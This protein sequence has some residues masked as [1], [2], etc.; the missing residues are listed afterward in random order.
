VVQVE[1]QVRREPQVQMVHLVQMVV[2]EQVAQV[3]HQE[4]LVA[5]VL[6]EHLVQVEQAAQWYIWL[7]RY[8]R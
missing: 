5:Q 3:V 1:L 6:Q 4:H 8:I 7:K 2:Q